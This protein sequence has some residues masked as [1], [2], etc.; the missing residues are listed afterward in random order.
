[1][2]DSWQDAKGDEVQA[3]S[4]RGDCGGVFQSRK[5]IYGPRRPTRSP[6]LTAD[7]SALLTSKPDILS[8]WKVYYATLLN[9]SSEINYQFLESIQHCPTR[10][11]TKREIEQAIA[12]TANSYW[13]S[14]E[15]LQDFKDALIVNIYKRKGDR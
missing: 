14:G 15:L 13:K 8:R 4:D 10:D 11:E 2:E 1:M 12:S 3:L 6:M 7:G 5:S 9:R